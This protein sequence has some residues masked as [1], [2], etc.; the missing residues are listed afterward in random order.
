MPVEEILQEVR[1]AAGVRGCFLIAKDGS[2]Q[3]TSMPAGPGEVELVAVAR[4]LSR[5]MEAL[6]AS[7]QHVQELDLTFRNGRVIVRNLPSGKL[8]LVCQAQINLPL[9]NLT[10]A[11]LL[12]RLAAETKP[13][14]SPKEEAP[15][16]F[17]AVAKGN[18]PLPSREDPPLLQRLVE[19]GQAIVR[20][21]RER[22]LTVR[23]IGTAGVVLHC[24]AGKQ[25]MLPP[26]QPVVELVG[27]ASE[28]EGLP[29]VF[30]QLG[31]DP[32]GRF[33]EE[34]RRQ[35]LIFKKKDPE[36]WA[37]IHL[38]SY[39]GFH[40]LEILESLRAEEELL[41]PT[42]LLL[43][44]LQKAEATDSDLRELIALLWDHELFTGPGAEAVDVTRIAKI[45]GEDWGW[46]RTTT[47][48]LDRLRF[49]GSWGGLPDSAALLD[50]IQRLREEI[51]NGPKGARWQMRAAIGDTVRWYKQAIPVEGMPVKEARPG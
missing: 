48:N 8:A 10:L 33:N 1:Q 3:G 20:G 27:R 23:I 29:G 25:W 11:P 6:E 4:A 44:G 15:A 28:A 42:D 39:D 35:R 34:H 31:Y 16:V 17:E 18:A 49:M 51:E 46:Y 41:P 7:R 22:G 19:E 50:R 12:K 43:L 40:R 14:A 21:A 13:P 36:L 38:D 30:G 2:L 32:L 9:L 5:S 37:D 26:S 24:P 47:R 45:C